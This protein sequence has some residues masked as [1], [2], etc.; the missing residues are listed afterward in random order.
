MKPPRR[1]DDAASCA[2]VRCSVRRSHDCADDAPIAGDRESFTTTL[3]SRR[4]AAGVRGRHQVPHQK[5]ALVL[6]LLRDVPAGRRLRDLTE[7]MHVLVAGERE[8]LV[9]A[10]G[11]VGAREEFRLERHAPV[12]EPVEVFEAAFAIRLDEIRVGLGSACGHH[13]LEHLFGRVVEAARLLD[14]R[15][16]AEIEEPAR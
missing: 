7:W 6:D 4:D 13:V 12:H 10:E 11:L 3:H 5:A 1:E 2:N 15:A 9:G 16:P 8:P 14:R